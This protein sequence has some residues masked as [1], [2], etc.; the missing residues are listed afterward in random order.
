TMTSKGKRLAAEVAEG[1]AFQAAEAAVDDA[2][3]RAEV[4]TLTS[5]TPFGRS[6]GGGISYTVDP[7]YLGSD[8][9]DNDGDSLVD[10]ADEN[11]FRLLVVGRYRNVARRFAA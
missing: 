6:L 7:L 5:G 9:N 4:G 2:V 8:G 11:V 1:K 10:E 3:Y